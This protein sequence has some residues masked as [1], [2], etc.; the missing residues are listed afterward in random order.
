MNRIFAE[1]Q[2]FFFFQ[3]AVAAAHIILYIGVLYYIINIII[4]TL[5]IIYI[6]NERW[7]S[8]KKKIK[9]KF[10]GEMK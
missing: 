7:R 8:A 9:I 2:V 5:S 1:N 3:R 10:L 4:F 6:F